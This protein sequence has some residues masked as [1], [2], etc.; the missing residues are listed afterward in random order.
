MHIGVMF[1]TL[2]V[3]SSTGGIERVCRIAGKAIYENCTRNN[4][5]VKIYSMH[6]SQLSATDN[7]YFPTE[8]FTG[9]NVNKFQFTWKAIWQ[10]K[11]S[12]LIILSHVNLLII[13]WVLKKIKPS[14]RVVLIAHGIEI[15]DEMSSFKKKMLACCDEIVS[16]SEYT[17][18][19][20][21][22][23]QQADP[24]KCSVINNCL[25]PFMILPKNV[26]GMDELRKRYGFKETDRIL[27]TLTRLAAKERY[28][29][30]DKV[31]E[32][33]INIKD[34]SV[35]YLIAGSYDA[36]EKKFIDDLVSSLHLQDRVVLAGFIPEDEVAA[37]FTMSDCYVMPSVKEGFGIVFIE[38]M[39]YNLP[40]IAGNKDGSVD[41]LRNGELGTLV[42]P[43]DVEGIKN[44]IE[45]IL[46]NPKKFAPDQK[47]LLDHFSYQSYKTKMN[48]LIARHTQARV[49]EKLPASHRLS[50]L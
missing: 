43:S 18:E 45:A 16:V 24:A 30:Y 35:K 37:H 26:T 13:A 10:G 32:A 5:R 4:K 38:A 9:F 25:D 17:R 21:V 41:A 6:D 34:P 46:A 49:I 22:K 7:L 8:L 23:L 40:V 39:Y 47:M 15:W 27:F 12:E 44:A 3:F 28:K 2:K 50:S 48:A 19:K 1:L 33:L 42:N 14:I 29:G 20:I 11:K 36:E 31:M